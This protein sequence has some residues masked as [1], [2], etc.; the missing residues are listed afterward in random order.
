MYETFL[1]GWVILCDHFFCFTTYIKQLTPDL[2]S[3]FESNRSQDNNF[4]VFILSL[5]SSPE[6]KAHKVS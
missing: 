5:F 2:R 1:L 6:P 4:D 3:S